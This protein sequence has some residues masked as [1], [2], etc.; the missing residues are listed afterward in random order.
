M[1]SHPSYDAYAT[2]DK[3]WALLDAMAEIAKARGG[4][5]AQVALRWLL[6]KRVTTAIVIGAKNVEQLHDNIAC[7]KVK[8]TDEDMAQL[9]ALSFAANF[10]DALPYPYE[11]VTRLNVARRR[12]I[13]K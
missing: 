4:S 2:N 10:G 9:D 8:L 12:P 1:Q 11:M 5:V 6:Q 3:V 13:G 7:S